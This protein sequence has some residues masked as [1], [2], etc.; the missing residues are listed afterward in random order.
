MFLSFS[1]FFFL[2]WL[3]RLIARLLSITKTFNL[4]HF[5]RRIIPTS[6]TLK[7]AEENAICMSALKNR[8]FVL[9]STSGKFYSLRMFMSGFLIAQFQK[10][11]VV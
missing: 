7:K 10:N 11:S 4:I 1:C 6:P 3:A 2:T 5:L 8:N 9:G